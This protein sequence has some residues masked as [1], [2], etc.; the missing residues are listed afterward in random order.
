MPSAYE[1]LLVIKESTSRIA[2][3]LDCLRASGLLAPSIAEIHKLMAL[4]VGAAT[5]QSVML[6]LAERELKM[7]SETEKARLDLEKRLNGIA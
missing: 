6:N 5:C 4:Q 3:Q 2:E 7:A 1:S